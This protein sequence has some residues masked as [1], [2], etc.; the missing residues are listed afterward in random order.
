MAAKKL[1]STEKLERLVQRMSF[2]V[3]VGDKQL[4]CK[5]C[6]RVVSYQPDKPSQIKWTHLKSKGHLERRSQLEKLNVR[7]P[8]DPQQAGI[9]E[10]PDLVRRSNRS[11]NWRVGPRL[12]IKEKLNRLAERNPCFV[13]IGD[14]QLYCK[15]C[16]E[17]VTFDPNKVCQ[18]K[19]HHLSTIRHR[20]KSSRLDQRNINRVTN[21]HK[22]AKTSHNNTVAK[23][24]QCSLDISFA[25]S[26]Q[27]ISQSAVGVSNINGQP[28]NLLQTDQV[29]CH[30]TVN[31]LSAGA[32]ED[33]A[34]DLA[35]ALAASDVPLYVLETQAFRDFLAKWT[36]L[37]VTSTPIQS[38]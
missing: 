26:C 15:V 2:L 3:I 34:S 24:T 12:P 7:Y 23:A 28:L 17:F 38:F 11:D 31:Q 29:H 18:V 9:L 36:G 6:D 27:T 33:F 16:D 8:R 37:F 19:W 21:G 22:P 13:V 20:E 10:A 25:Q 32:R 30:Q 1:P 14:D 35:G 5:I 4:F